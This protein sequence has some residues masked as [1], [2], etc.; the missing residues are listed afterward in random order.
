MTFLLTAQMTEH[1]LH[2]KGWIPRT[3]DLPP[4]HIFLPLEQVQVFSQAQ[5]WF[6][7]QHPEEAD[8]LYLVFGTLSTPSGPSLSPQPLSIQTFWTVAKS[9]QDALEQAHPESLAWTPCGALL[10]TELLQWL[11]SYPNA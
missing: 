10:G 8:H 9:S 3:L 4:Q 6:A 1:G 11:R 5:S 2:W 7:K